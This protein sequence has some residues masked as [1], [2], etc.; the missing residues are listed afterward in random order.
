MKLRHFDEPI[1]GQL[2][3]LG[4]LVTHLG[5]EIPAD[6]QLPPNMTIAPWVS[7]PRMFHLTIKGRIVA[8]PAR[9]DLLESYVYA[10]LS[11]PE[12]ELIFQAIQDV[13]EHGE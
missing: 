3:V 11:D 6:F 10:L 8:G 12:K 4:K 9:R 5:E 7:F 13:V 2:I 1:S